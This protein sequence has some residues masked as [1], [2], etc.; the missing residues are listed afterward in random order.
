MKTYIAKNVRRKGVHS[1]LARLLDLL[2]L[3]LNGLYPIPMLTNRRS[4]DERQRRIY[5]L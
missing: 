1:V 2:G 4:N 3:K 5:S